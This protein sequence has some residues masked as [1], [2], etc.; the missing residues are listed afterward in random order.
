MG[1]YVLSMF[2]GETISIIEWDPDI[3]RKYADGS[4][5]CRIKGCTQKKVNGRCSLNLIRT[6]RDRFGN[7]RDCLDMAITCSICQRDTPYEYTEKHHLIPRCKKGKKT[8]T[9]PVCND[10]G[11]YV[12]QIFTEKELAKEYNTLEKL[13]ADPKIQ[14]WIAWIK[15]KKKFGICMKRKK[16]R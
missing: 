12:H 15:N 6:G 10:C 16:R 3:V 2:E 7:L 5:P 9:I 8:P 11:N 1:Y 13:L 4:Y 14:K